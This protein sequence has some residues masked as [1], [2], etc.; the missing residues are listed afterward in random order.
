MTLGMTTDTSCT[1]ANIAL[2]YINYD[3]TFTAKI[4][5][6]LIWVKVT[7]GT[8]EINHFRFRNLY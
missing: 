2:L 3:V 4:G 7:E 1:K 6:E 8:A 5:N